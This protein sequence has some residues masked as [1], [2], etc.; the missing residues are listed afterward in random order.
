MKLTKKVLKEM[1]DEELNEFF[2]FQGGDMGPP[3]MEE[4]LKILQHLVDVWR[5]NDHPISTEYSKELQS[6]IDEMKARMETKDK[7]IE[8]GRGDWETYDPYTKPRE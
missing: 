5:R 4:L 2:K 3:S 1:I 7:P 8:P 6:V